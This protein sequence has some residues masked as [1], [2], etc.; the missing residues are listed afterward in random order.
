MRSIRAM[1][2]TSMICF[3]KLARNCRVKTHSNTGVS[4]R[5]KFSLKADI[6]DFK[7]GQSLNWS[8]ASVLSASGSRLCGACKKGFPILHSPKTKAFLRKLSACKPWSPKL[9]EGFIVTSL[10]F[11]ASQIRASYQS[12]LRQVPKGQQ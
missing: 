5:D 2:G 7:F 3:A 4:S 1:N 10:R 6:L 9:G 11:A 8:S 12:Y